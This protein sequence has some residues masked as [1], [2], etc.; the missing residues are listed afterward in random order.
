MQ[1][2]V[3][4]VEIMSLE[5]LLCPKCNKGKIRVWVYPRYIMVKRGFTGRSYLDFH[6][7][8]TEILTEQCP[9]CKTHKKE[10]RKW[11]R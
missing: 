5:E 6:K 2:V 10:L 1:K 9:E 11:L 3:G 7:S 4:K 8:K